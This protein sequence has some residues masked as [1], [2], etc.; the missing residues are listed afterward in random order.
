MKLFAGSYERFLFGF[1]LQEGPGD[2]T[3]RQETSQ[4]AHRNAVKCIDSRGDFVAT[5]GA[6][7]QIH[8]FDMGHEKDLGFVINPVEGAVPCLAFVCPDN[9]WQPSH[10]LS[11]AFP[12]PSSKENEIHL[13]QLVRVRLND[14]GA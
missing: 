10:F 7:D 12:A 5:G 3:L 8:L 4:P 9:C 13:K 14:T 1:D 6:D 11:G 2:V